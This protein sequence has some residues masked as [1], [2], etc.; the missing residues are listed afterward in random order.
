MFDVSN[1]MTVVTASVLALLSCVGIAA[2]D[3][4]WEFVTEFGDFAGVED[5]ALDAQGDVY[6][7]DR[8]NG[9]IQVFTADGQYLRE[10][11]GFN[12]PT[13]MAIDENDMIYVIQG[14]LVH[15]F[16]IDFQQ[17]GSWDNC[18]GQGDL[19]R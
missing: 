8:G 6:V 11:A 2:A 1:R 10:M 19:R 13:C 16:D 5:I 7:L 15:Q 18:M 14:C 17:V 9:R 4:E 12:D 3:G